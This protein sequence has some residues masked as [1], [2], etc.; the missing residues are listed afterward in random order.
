MRSRTELPGAIGQGAVVTLK[1]PFGKRK[2]N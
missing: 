1:I 2:R